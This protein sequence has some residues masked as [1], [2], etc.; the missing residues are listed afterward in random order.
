MEIKVKINKWTELK[1]FAKPRKPT[2][3]QQNTLNGR[4]YLQIICSIKG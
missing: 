3:K 2:T 1:A 4:K